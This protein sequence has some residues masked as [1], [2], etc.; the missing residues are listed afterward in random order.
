VRRTP[1]IEAL[2]VQTA[3]GPLLFPPLGHELG[4]DE[5][6]FLLRTR[7]IFEQRLLL[8]AGA[9]PENAPARA[10]PGKQRF[11]KSPPA[12]EWGWFPWY[13]DSGLHVLF[14][15]RDATG[16]VIGVELDRMRLLAD[17]IAVLPP[18]AGEESTLADDE[19][20]VLVD[21]NGREV[22]SWGRPPFES[23]RVVQIRRS[24]TPPLGS[25]V[26][27]HERPARSG[28]VGVFSR[29]AG[30]VVAG[31]VLTGLA[32]YFY[33]ESSRELR[34]ARQR[35]R[36]VSQVS[37]ELR[38]PL[39]NI[40]LYAELLESG[41]AEDEVTAHDHVGVIVSESERLSRLIDNV[42]AFARHGRG[43]LTIR[44]A[45]GDLDE[46]VAGI[47]ERY[48]PLLAARDVDV[49]IRLDAPAR[50][51]FDTDAVSQILGNLLNNVE[52]YAPNS[53]PL[54]ISTGQRNG[55]TL[56]RVADSGPGIA[57]RDRERVFE[58]FVRLSDRVSEGAAG[59]GIG[60]T[61]AREL[62]RLQ[63]GDLRLVRSETG[64]CFELELPLAGDGSTP[65]RREEHA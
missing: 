46:V 5:A 28:A 50:T 19:R 3:D 20:V 30:L 57:D 43:E 4:S 25:W 8:N 49:E 13:W 11:I 36:F 32:V 18:G 52:K 37:H 10:T 29:A 42:L 27:R 64:A 44:T 65:D 23:Q 62:A 35:V 45:A 63:N 16:N 1:E 15:R 26:V 61:I 59:T 34:E 56:V 24:L 47:V 33:R 54:T 40:R 38:T 21:A 12:P 31:V 9:D 7:Q 39:T 51:R 2:F 48:R 14:W 22:Y 53:G 17:I 60:L 58:A 55:V 41:L 6:A